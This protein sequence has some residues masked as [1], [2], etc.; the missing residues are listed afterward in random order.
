V[1]KEI[2]RMART[3]PGTTGNEDAVFSGWQKTSWGGLFA[4][5]TITATG[6]PS[7]GSTVTD[8]SLLKL[9]LRIP[10]TPLRPV[11]GR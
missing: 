1:F 11:T 8:K 10:R 7:L 5:Y 4:L 6:H 3:L 2:S 9:N